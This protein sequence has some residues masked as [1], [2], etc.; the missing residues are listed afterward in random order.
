MDP[1]Q[2]P[3]GSGPTQR[4]LALE[5][6]RIIAAG[7]VR[8]VWWWPGVVAVVAVYVV[9]A[10]SLYHHSYPNLWGGLAAVV[11]ALAWYASPLRNVEARRRKRLSAGRPG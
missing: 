7:A 4:S 2:T 10:V 3:D 5:E 1:P 8:L 6:L 9:V 11:A